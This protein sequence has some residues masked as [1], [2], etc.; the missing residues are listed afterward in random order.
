MTSV[1]GSSVTSAFIDLATYDTI[2]KHLY[3][4]DSAVAY[5]VRETKKCT[6][7]SKLPVLLTRCSGSPNFDQEFSVNVSRGGDYVLNSWMTVRI[8][9]IKLKAD[10][11]MN[12]NG[13]IRWCKNLFHN[14]IKQT[15]VQFNDL[16][17]Q[18][19]ESYFLDYWAAFSMCGS[20]RAGY[21]NMIGNTI[22]MIQPVDHTGM[23]PE[24]VLVL[25]LPYFFSRDSGV[26][27]PSAALPYNE[28]RLTFHLRD[29]TELLIFQHKQ[30]CT[31]IPITAA[32]LEYGKP[33]LKDV[34]V[35]ITNAVVTNEERRLMGTTPRDIL[36]E[37][38]Q[39][40]PKHVFQPLT[41]PSPNFDIRFSH[42]IKLLFFGVRNTTHAAVQSNYTT[43][44]P[45]ILEEAY[46]SDLSLVAADPI[47][48]V[49]LVYENSA[50]LN[51]MGSEYYSLVQ[52]YYFGGSIPIETGY[53]M[54][55][56]SLNMMDMDPMGSTNY[57]R[58]SNVSMKLKTSDKAVV[59]AGGGGGNMSGYKDAQKFE[60]LTMAINHNVIRIKNGSMG[61]PVL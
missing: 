20:K 35:W 42:A 8:P 33:D 23:L 27:L 47:A 18:K 21:N 60:F 16:V 39:T 41:I 46:A 32:D 3:G 22:D 52:P 10:N 49:T 61:F 57:G 28:I 40:A 48:N 12:N 14:L 54:Y 43:A 34:Q 29:Y 19:F 7:F 53:H 58:L 30:D 26:A 5:F 38:V 50:R 4:G 9:A 51:E 56:Y 2:E 25:P 6:W 37:Q 24:K 36:V 59:N 17:A 13:T 55:C 11:R 44:S 31:I 45:V 1:A 15:S